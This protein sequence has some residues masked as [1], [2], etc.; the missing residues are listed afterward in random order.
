M[1]GQSIMPNNITFLPP[2]SHTSGTLLGY[3]GYFGVGGNLM[4]GRTVMLQWDWRL[5]HKELKDQINHF[6]QVKISV[7][8]FI[9]HLQ[10]SC[11][12]FQS[13]LS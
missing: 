9:L 5:S 6:I 10:K 11:R 2:S 12:E 13:I 1:A 3:R 7:E 8:F 4:V